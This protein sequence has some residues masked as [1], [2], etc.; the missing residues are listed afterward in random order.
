LS[1]F[2]YWL[3]PVNSGGFWVRQ[4]TTQEWGTEMTA[5]KGWRSGKVRRPRDQVQQFVDVLT[6]EMPPGIEYHLLGS[7][8]RGAPTIGDLDIVIV[9]E[10][11]TLNDDLFQDGVPLPPSFYAQRFGARIAQGDLV[12]ADRSSIHLDVW[13]C[14]PRQRGGFLCFATGPA[15][16]NLAQR[17]R[18]IKLGFALSQNGL[19]DAT[20]KEQLDNGT[21]EHIY[22]LI[23]WPWLTPEARQKWAEIDVRK[24]GR[25]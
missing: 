10:S 12:L 17:S 11:G 16:L 25:S 7:W 21:E 3:T 2:P 15:A 9:T 14:S 22:E 1:A 5:G 4:A 18:A 13:S 23:G 8:R 19:F 20:T 6:A 24:G